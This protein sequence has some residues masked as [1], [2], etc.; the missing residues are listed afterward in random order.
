MTWYRHQLGALDSIT[1]EQNAGI[2]A[3][4][5]CTKFSCQQDEFG[6]SEIRKADEFNC[7]HCGKWHSKWMLKDGQMTHI[8]EMQ[9]NELDW[10]QRIYSNLV[11]WSCYLEEVEYVLLAEQEAHKQ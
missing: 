6:K 10:N 8:G 11:C 9:R 3:R 2:V 4:I 1:P 5:G 7:T